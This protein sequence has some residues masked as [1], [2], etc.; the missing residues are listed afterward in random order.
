MRWSRRP[1]SGAPAPAGD[2]DAVAPIRDDLDRARADLDELG[3]C[4]VAGLLALDELDELVALTAAAAAAE[5]ADGTA[6]TYGGGNQRVWT[7]PHRHE[8]YLRLAEHPTALGLIE[9]VIGPG[10]LLSNLTANVSDA[11]GAALAPHFDQHWAPRPWPYALVANAI[12]MLDDFTAENGATVLVP[13]SHRGDG[14]PAADALVAATGPRG[15][16]LVVDGR[17][18]HGTGANVS[19]RRRMGLLAYYCRPWLRPQEA[20]PRSL[21][22]EVA[23]GLD[24]ERRRLLGFEF[25]EYLNMVGGPPQ[26]VRDRPSPTA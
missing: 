16:C 24:P 1:A 21:P 8:A 4:R 11:G 14:E 2:L 9:H 5:R 13:R 22:S 26:W 17:V 20:F 3:A 25:H 19:G 12:W 15:T 23:A 6:Y 18:W 10:A 7:L